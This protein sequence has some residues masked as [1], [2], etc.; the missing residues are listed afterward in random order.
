ME[1]KKATTRSQD[2]QQRSVISQGNPVCLEG[3]PL[4]A[5]YSGN[6]SQTKSG[7]TC[8]AWSAQEPHEHSYTEVGEHNHCRNPF[9][10]PIGVWCYTTDENKRWEHCSVPIC[11]GKLKV[12]DFSADSDQELDSNGEYTGATLEAGPLPESFT[13]CSAF[14]VEAWAT[15]F[16]FVD[17]FRLRDK[18]GDPVWTK[19]SLFA[20][21]GYT[22]YD[23]WLG[24]NGPYFINQT[25]TQFFPLQWTRVCLSLDFEGKVTLVVDGQLL[26]EQEYIREDDTRYR[27]ANMSLV[28]GFDTDTDSEY[29]GRVSELN[30]FSPSLSVERMIGQTLAGGQ[31][32]GAPG[33][34]VNWEE[35]EWTLHSQAKLVEV[36]GEWEG[37]CRRESQVFTTDFSWH[38]DCMHHCQKISGGRS[39]PVT[40]REE[41][42]SLTR[43]VDLIT[44]ERADLPYMWLSATE[45]DIKLKLATLEHWPDTEVVKN[46]TQKLEAVE[47]I[48]RDFYTGQRLTNWTKPYY[49]PRFQ[50]S[51]S[52]ETDNCMA[53]YHDEPWEESWYEFQC[54]TY[55]QSCP[56][57]YLI[58][59]TSPRA[60]LV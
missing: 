51:K 27:P 23:G 35:A 8:Q 9:G 46:K 56:C 48:W 19:V 59:V 3:N 38:V 28:L 12:L 20:G 30:I 7:R 52:G 50:D 45:G 31:E 11:G 13:I 16:S 42:E 39:P 41:W 55:D 44:R 37:P 54:Q 14:M 5:S 40:T 47:T 43:E 18:W 32:C 4:G 10:D 60:R 1:R 25:E 58:F 34:L 6:M 53:V 22:E 49:S 57:T 33:N 2:R 26:A 29:D 15:Q 21:P 17:L 24:T 36:D